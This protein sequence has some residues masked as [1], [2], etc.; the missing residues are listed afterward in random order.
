[1]K[2]NNEARIKETLLDDVKGVVG[3]IHRMNA[4]YAKG[5]AFDATKGNKSIARGMYIDR[6][7]EA[8]EYD[9]YLDFKTGDL[10]NTRQ[11]L[12]KINQC[13]TWGKKRTNI[14]IKKRKTT[15]P[16]VSRLK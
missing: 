4:P 6:V 1:M 2:I 11:R 12:V 7:G 3:S 16:K 9:Y 13:G 14:P 8:D 5:Y 15:K 10:V